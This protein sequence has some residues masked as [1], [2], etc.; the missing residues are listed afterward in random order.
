MLVTLL[1]FAQVTS[2]WKFQKFSQKNSLGGRI[3][4]FTLSQLADIRVFSRV[5]GS[6]KD[7]A[8]GFSFLKKKI[9]LKIS[10]KIPKYSSPKRH[11]VSSERWGNPHIRRQFRKLES[12]F[13]KKVR[14][15]S[16]HACKGLTDWL[17]LIGSLISLMSWPQWRSKWRNLRHLYRLSSR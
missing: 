4:P 9:F 17:I 1:L 11:H 10:R 3:R 6:K 5:V 14:S 2:N 12:K 16:Q 8:R 13:N 7:Q 15:L